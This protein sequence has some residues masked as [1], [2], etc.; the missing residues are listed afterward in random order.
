MGGCPPRAGKAGFALVLP[1]AHRPIRRQGAAA[2]ER[3]AN[4]TPSF[5]PWSLPTATE[6]YVLA[7]DRAYG[8]CCGQ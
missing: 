7:L 6:A 2:Q 5:S 3:A 8:V 1:A 4:V